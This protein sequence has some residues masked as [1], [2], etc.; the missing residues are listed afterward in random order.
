MPEAARHHGPALASRFTQQPRKPA[1]GGTL[2]T[3]TLLFA[4]LVIDTVLLVGALSYLPVPARGPVM[5]QLAL[6]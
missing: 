1:T 2:P 4:E 6:R 3:D 5:E